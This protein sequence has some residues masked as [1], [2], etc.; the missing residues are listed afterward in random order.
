M[1]PDVPIGLFLSTNG[2]RAVRLAP[3]FAYFFIWLPTL[4]PLPHIKQA[5]FCAI[6]RICLRISPAE[7]HTASHSSARAHTRDS[8]T[9]PHVPFS[10]AS[11]DG[12]RDASH[13]SGIEP[14]L[15]RRHL[16]HRNHFITTISSFDSVRPPR[17]AQHP[18]TSPTCCYTGTLSTPATAFGVLPDRPCR[19]SRFAI[20]VEASFARVPSVYALSATGPI[21]R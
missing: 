20:A 19:G 21:L 3:L 12:I 18:T 7:G 11:H 14:K 10:P 13:A 8:D 4:Q 17:L 15:Q 6:P 5:L 1:L 16:A 2:E 9:T